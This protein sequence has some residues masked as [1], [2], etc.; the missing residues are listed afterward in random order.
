MDSDHEGE[1][2]GVENKP[3]K[4]RVRKEEVDVV[5]TGGDGF[6]KVDQFSLYTV[7][8]GTRPDAFP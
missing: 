7:L 4:S 3:S 2:R 6:A 5:F 8:A 1:E